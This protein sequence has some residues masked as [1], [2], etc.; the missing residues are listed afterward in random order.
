MP[1]V[2]TPLVSKDPAGPLTSWR[3]AEFRRSIKISRISRLPIAISRITSATLSGA[4]ANTAS[5]IASQRHA[6]RSRT[7]RRG[8]GIGR[9]GHVDRRSPATWPEFTQLRHRSAQLRPGIRGCGT[10]DVWVWYYDLADRTG[11]SHRRRP[12]PWPAHPNTRRR[13]S[14]DSHTPP[15]KVAMVR[16]SATATAD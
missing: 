3:W 15:T 4:D 9:S 11:R 2:A 16:R 13:L 1:M 8:G 6:H 14:G 7:I 5:G 12:S 10:V